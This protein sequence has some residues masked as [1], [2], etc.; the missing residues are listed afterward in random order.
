MQICNHTFPLIK[1]SY[2]F[3]MKLNWSSGGSAWLV[4]PLRIGLSKNVNFILFIADNTDVYCWKDCK[5]A[6]FFSSN[7]CTNKLMFYS[8]WTSNINYNKE[9][10]DMATVIHSNRIFSSGIAGVGTYLNFQ[11]LIVKMCYS[12]KFINVWV[13]G[14]K[15]LFWLRN[16]DINVPWQTPY[17]LFNRRYFRSA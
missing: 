8:P 6:S 14:A 2:C 4:F 12:K 9:A 15:L 7:A 17:C 13:V 3:S 11:N 5:N 10:V 16:C 1:I